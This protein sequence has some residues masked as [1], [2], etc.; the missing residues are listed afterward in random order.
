M[1][2]SAKKPCTYPGCGRLVEGGGKSRCDLH[3]KKEERERSARRRADPTD[4]VHLYRSARWRS[5]RALFMRQHSMCAQCKRDGA[6]TPA[7]EM[8]HIISVKDGGEFW[9]LNNWQSL[10]HACH[11][12][13]T[14]RE[15][16]RRGVMRD[17]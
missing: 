2:N 8:D 3:R 13:K 6:L 7:T 15:L 14:M 9:D 12:R 4:D 17:G 11:S 16:N 10:C 1:P 5:A